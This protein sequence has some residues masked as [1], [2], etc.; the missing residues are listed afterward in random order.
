MIGVGEVLTAMGALTAAY[1]ALGEALDV[2]AVR[3]DAIVCAHL[4]DV[5]QAAK[6]KH[7]ILDRLL[8]ER[9][10]KAA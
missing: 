5:R 9:S 7:Q 4:E 6:R 3:R 2:T 8:I 10:E 1:N